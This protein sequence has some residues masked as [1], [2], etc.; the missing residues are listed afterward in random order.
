M[1][2][3]QK[4]FYFYELNAMFFKDGN[5]DGVGDL[6][7]IIEKVKYF[8]FLGVDYIILTNFLEV[9]EHNNTFFSYKSIHKSIGNIKNFATLTKALKENNIKLIIDINV[10]TISENHIWYKKVVSD[11]KKIL[12]TKI[13]LNQQIKYNYKTKTYYI[14]NDGIREANIDWFNKNIKD[15]FSDVVKLWTQLGVSGFRFTNINYMISNENKTIDILNRL[16]TIIKKIDSNLLIIGQIDKNNLRASDYYQVLDF[17]QYTNTS[18]LG[19]SK[20]HGNDVIGK[21]KVSHLIKEIKS[22]T[23]IKKVVISF[24][25]NKVGRILSRW[26]SSFVYWNES[27]KA[28]ALLKLII[29]GSKVIYYGDEIGLTNIGLE[30]MD[31]FLDLNI[32]ERQKELKYKFNI[33]YREFINAQTLQNHINAHSLMSWNSKKNGGFTSSAFPIMV[34]CKSYKRIN[35]ISQYSDKNSILN[36]YSMLIN[37][38]KNSIY[39]N[40]IQSGKLKIKKYKYKN[41]IKIIRQDLDKKIIAF[42]NFGHSLIKFRANK[43]LKSADLLFLNYQEKMKNSPFLNGF[44]IIVFGI[45]YLKNIV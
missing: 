28:I 25:S 2:L 1:N 22:L 39:N 26:G 10:G 37:F 12:N 9:H 33:S 27:G 45:D 35:V 19:T 17:L 21:F 15:M 29:S 13:S 8:K 38:C 44:E 3:E 42:I 6:L 34:P 16:R 11:S 36:F 4:V 40:V 18:L 24:A 20:K 14:I 31:D 23:K 5:N 41:L 7:G 43:F 32:V 30:K